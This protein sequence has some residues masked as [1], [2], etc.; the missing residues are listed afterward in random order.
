M[1][2]NALYYPYIDV[3]NEKWLLHTL[4]YWEKLYSIVPIKYY[5]EPELHS[6]FMQRLLQENLVVPIVPSQYVRCDD[7]ALFADKIEDYIKDGNPKINLKSKNRSCIHVEKLGDIASRLESLDVVEN[8]GNGWLSMPKNIADLFMQYIAQNISKKSSISADAITYNNFYKYNNKRTN[9][10]RNNVLEFLIPVPDGTISF[11][12]LHKF[13]EKHHKILAKF[14]MFVENIIIEIQ[15]FVDNGENYE[16]VKM[17]VF[18]QM[19]F[20]IRE[21]EDAMKGQWKNVILNK[22]VPLFTIGLHCFCDNV[23]PEV[24]VIGMIAPWFGGNE[25]NYSREPLSYSVFARNKLNLKPSF[26]FRK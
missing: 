12:D 26:T 6:L 14:R 9:E 25:I 16:E 21:I 24:D 15:Q 8:I 11:E 13:K 23:P 1:Q 3:P 7:L 18:K 19:D 4:L 20:E 5:Y 22:I 17:S 10:I 2:S